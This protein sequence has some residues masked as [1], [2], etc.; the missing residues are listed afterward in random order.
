MNKRTLKNYLKKMRFVEI[1][2]DVFL[3]EPRKFNT[4]C[5]YKDSILIHAGCRLYFAFNFS[6]YKSL[7]EYSTISIDGCEL[8][9]YDNEYLFNELEL[10]NDCK[11]SEGHFLDELTNFKK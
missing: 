4:F 3:N 6:K 1:D 9:T 5:T 11:K 8:N 10:F 7:Y 2:A